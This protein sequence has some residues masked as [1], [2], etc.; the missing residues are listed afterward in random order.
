MSGKTINADLLERLPGSPPPSRRLTATGN[1]VREQLDLARHAIRNVASGRKLMQMI[2]SEPG[3]GKTYLTLQ[4][5]RALGI[6]VD[7]VAPA[8]DV[9]F[10]EV[11]Y[12]YRDEKV[13]VL[14]DSDGLARS[15]RVASITKM[16]FGPTGTVIRDT[17]KARKNAL[18]E[19]NDK[20]DPSIP[21]PQFKV[22]CGLIW[23]T[24]INFTDPANIANHMAPHF[25]ALCSRGL[26]PMWIDTSDTE[27]LFRYCVWLG[28]E[29]N[30]L[31]GLQ[32]TKPVSEAAIKWFIENRDCLREVSPRTLRRCAETMMQ[33]Y[34]ETELE[35]ALK[36]FMFGD[37]VQSLP[38]MQIPRITGGKWA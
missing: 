25:R 5:L 29:G 11:L 19:G 36:A 14:D 17:S 34:N 33:G 23:L 2:G 26:D 13:I 1:K 32:I 16:A 28:T 30:M 6:R 20:H 10:V 24:N 3:L 31:R 27:D 4:E 37:P 35:L 9:A 15:E 38:N 22:R 8:T 21:P 18:K 12:D 7:W